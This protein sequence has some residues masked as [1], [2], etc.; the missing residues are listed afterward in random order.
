MAVSLSE[1]IE[2][3]EG[4]A[5]LSLQESYDNS[6]LLLG[7]SDKIVNKALI[8]LDLSEDVMTE[9]VETGADLILTHHPFIFE[10]I[11]KIN[12]TTPCER[13]IQMGIKNEIAVYSAH[14]NLDNS[15][16]GMNRMFCEQLGL[17]NFSILKP[18]KEVLRK[19]VVF[20]PKD[21]AETVRSALFGAGAGHIGNYEYCSF[22]SNGTGTFRG[23]EGSNPFAGVQGHLHYEE[24]IRIETV[25]PAYIEKMVLQAMFKA[26]PY[27][28]IAYDIYP[29]ANEYAYAGS[30]MIGEFESEKALT[31]F[32]SEVKEIF[33][34]SLIRHSGFT[35]NTV[36]KVAVCG[37]SGS[38]LIKDAIAAGADVFLSSD[39]KYHQFQQ[40]EGQIVIA[41]IG[42]YE[43]EQYIKNYLLTELI[44][45][46]PKFAVAL[47]KNCSNSVKYF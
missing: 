9:A 19:L 24:E 29:L 34:V 5:P 11:R 42:H 28:E 27:E 36:K 32:F 39:I 15:K 30:G 26:H 25:F 43:S 23:L 16:L 4:I 3:I 21:Y 1:I 41:D 35:R 6:G 47:A 33:S 18:M 7:S 46:F 40:A 38:F 44:K 14:T 8:A 37:G 20:C 2:L 22:N 45:K 10:P 13:I 12:G 31:T 17:V